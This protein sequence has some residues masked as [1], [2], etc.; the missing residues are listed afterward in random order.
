MEQQ[1]SFGQSEING[2]LLTHG[3]YNCPKVVKAVHIRSCRDALKAGQALWKTSI[4]ALR[5]RSTVRKAV[6]IVNL[7]F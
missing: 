4:V 3:T 5:L 2:S 6:G 1:N 7:L